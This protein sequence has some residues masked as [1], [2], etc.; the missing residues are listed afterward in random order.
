MVLCTLDMS[1]FWIA[2]SWLPTYFEEQRKMS[3]GSSAETVAIAYL[4]LLI[5]Q[6]ILRLRRRRDQATHI[7]L[8]FFR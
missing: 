8:R 2:F 1:A 7:I 3:I 5:G 6:V 4:G